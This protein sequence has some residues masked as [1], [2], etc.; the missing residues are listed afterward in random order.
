M[1]I[2]NYF[3]FF[4]ALLS[5]Q[6]A[7]AQNSLS[8]D[9]IDDKVDL[10]NGP[11]VQLTGTALTIEAWIYPTSWRTNV[12]EGGIVVKEQNTQAGYMFRAG[13]VG[14]LNFAFGP[15]GTGATWKELTTVANALTLN[16]WQHVAVTYDGAKVRLYKNGVRIDSASYTGSIGANANSCVIGGWYTT[17]R[18]FPGKIDE[19]RLWN[20]VRTQAQILSAMN[21][22]FCSAPTGM[23]AYYKFNQGAAGGTNTGLTTLT[24]VT[25]NSNGTLQ[26]FALS[27]A[28]SN[29]S[30][31]AAL[32]PGTGGSGTL[33][34]T[35]CDSYTS[36]SG[37]TYTA[38]GTY[39]DTVTS[40]LGCDSILT[41]N[42]T[43]N[44]NSSSTFA[45]TGCNDYTSPSGKH[46]W[47]SSGTYNDVIPNA[48]GCDSNMTINLTIKTI[49]INVLV[50]NASLTSWASAAVY[51]WLDCNNNYAAIPGA[52][53]QTFFPTASGSYAVEV[54]KNGCTDTTACYTI[55]GI[56]L[57]EFVGQNG[58]AMFP[59]PAKDF[60]TLHFKQTFSTI[61]IC[62]SNAVGQKLKEQN[63]VNT[64]TAELALDL[65]KGVY[66]LNIKADGKLFT[67][68]LIVE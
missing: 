63:F 46:T 31:G 48:I 12:F 11:K 13:Q 20:V 55:N 64:N 56:G 21:G 58:V 51:Q 42:L 65:P 22:E 30:T 26:G 10:G 60:T 24:D 29:W 28:T 27:G 66:L 61:D 39:V 7:V 57:E 45:A 4:I 15:G 52:T 34:T 67:Q 40:A 14:R 54:S 17:G 37:N 9:G 25:G 8:F 1:K 19:V 32:T 18:N 43:V 62:I 44:A 35:A 68:K 5:L 59:N 38:S 2:K 6:V 3:T 50:N 53:A 36:S 49:D 16:V 47:T 23:Q 41:L 33:T